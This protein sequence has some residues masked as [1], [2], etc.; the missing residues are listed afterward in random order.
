MAFLEKGY[1]R[2]DTNIEPDHDNFYGEMYERKWK[3]EEVKDI[4]DLG[5]KIMEELEGK[6]DPTN[7][8]HYTS[9][10]KEY[11][12]H[13]VMAVWGMDYHLSAAIK[14]LARAGKKKSAHLSDK[15]KETED[16]NKSITY[17]Q[18]RLEL[19]KEGIL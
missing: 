15:D 14:Y 1:V 19:M 5:D 17:I 3:N 8:Q 18:M 16:L 4:I 2:E 6:K 11:E 9:V 7:P 13:R 12:H 10:P